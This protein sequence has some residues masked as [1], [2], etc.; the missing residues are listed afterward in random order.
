MTPLTL[1]SN[2]PINLFQ[3]VPIDNFST[4][5][6]RVRLVIYSNPDYREVGTGIPRE[7]IARTSYNKLKERLERGER[8][9]LTI[10]DSDLHSEGYSDLHE[11][12]LF[13]GPE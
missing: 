9:V 4:N 1:T 5:Q 7:K 3:T 11:I 2:V 12:S 8:P 6:S 10:E 13:W